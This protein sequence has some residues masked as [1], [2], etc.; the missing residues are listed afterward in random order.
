MPL[1]VVV[2]RFVSAFGGAIAAG[3]GIVARS[4]RGSRNSL[5]KKSLRQ[6]RL[7]GLLQ[8]GIRANLTT[9]PSG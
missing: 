6:T 1:S 8:P 2:R 9:E 7:P 3:A 5:S 4:V